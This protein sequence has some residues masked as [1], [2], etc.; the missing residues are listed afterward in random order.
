MQ[1][2][3]RVGGVAFMVAMLVVGTALPS[4]AAFDYT[5]TFNGVGTELTTALQAIVPLVVVVFAIILGIRLAL[6]LF[7]TVAK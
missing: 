2:I 4:F 5:N 6:K 7:R 3:R 1:T